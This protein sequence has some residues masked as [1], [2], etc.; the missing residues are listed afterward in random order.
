MDA[1]VAAEIITGDAD[2]E[3]TVVVAA[4][5]TVDA[6]VETTAAAIMTGVEAGLTGPAL[7]TVMQ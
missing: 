7:M 6:A 1:A 5:T 3:T 4:E 2:V